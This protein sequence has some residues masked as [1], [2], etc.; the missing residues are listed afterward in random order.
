MA[1]GRSLANSWTSPRLTVGGQQREALD[2]QLVGGAEVPDGTVPAPGGIAIGFWTNRG[3][4]SCP[5]AQALDCFEGDVAYDAKMRA[6]PL[7]WMLPSL[8]RLPARRR[9]QAEPAFGS[10]QQVGNRSKKKSKKKK[11]CDSQCSSELAKDCSTW[12]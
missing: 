7:S 10:V 2:T 12:S 3:P 5:P 6:R 9:S 1:I 4:D 8:A 11:S